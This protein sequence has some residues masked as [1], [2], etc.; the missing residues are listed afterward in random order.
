MPAKRF[1]FTFLIYVFT[2]KITGNCE[3]VLLLLFGTVIISECQI[4]QLV[5]PDHLWV[6]K[7][8]KV[9][10]MKYAYA[11]SYQVKALFNQFPHVYNTTDWHMHVLLDLI[12]SE[13]RLVLCACKLINAKLTPWTAATLDQHLLE[14][15][16]QGGSTAPRPSLAARVAETWY[17]SSNHV[18]DQTWC[19]HNSEKIKTINKLMTL[20]VIL[21]A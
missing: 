17:S 4:A 7:V 5:L 8:R 6:T 11:V 21:I 9:S 3:N 2:T 20:S 13:L 12:I 18:L 1:W 19:T 14:R 16:P 10:D 15:R